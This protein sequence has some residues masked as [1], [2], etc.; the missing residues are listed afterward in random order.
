MVGSFYKNAL[1]V[2]TPI[3]SIA[4]SASSKFSRTKIRQRALAIVKNNGATARTRWGRS[5]QP[6]GRR[7]RL[8][9]SRAPLRTAVD[10]RRRD[11]ESP[12]PGG[13]DFERET[14]GSERASVCPL[15]AS[16]HL[17]SPHKHPVLP[18]SLFCLN[19][20]TN[21]AAGLT[22]LPPASSHLPRACTTCACIFHCTKYQPPMNH[23]E[24]TTIFMYSGARDRN[25]NQKR[26]IGANIRVFFPIWAP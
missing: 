8:E 20:K 7:L 24:I 25:N 15:A 13:V 1:N 11:L 5:A 6:R 23:G 16:L 14:G 19:K 10:M 21:G 3:R 4:V 17:L 9:A 12:S 2:A 22:V 18:R 26:D